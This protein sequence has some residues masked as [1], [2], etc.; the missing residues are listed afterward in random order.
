MKRIFKI[1]RKKFL[2][3]GEKCRKKVL[4]IRI[5]CDRN[6]LLGNASF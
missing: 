5:M 4:C 1:G 6:P 3:A 2:F